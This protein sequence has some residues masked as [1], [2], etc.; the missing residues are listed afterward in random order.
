MVVSEALRITP[1]SYQKWNAV[2]SLMGYRESVFLLALI[3]ASE[4]RCDKEMLKQ[5]I[6]PA[7][8]DVSDVLLA[9]VAHKTRKVLRAHNIMVNIQSISGFGYFLDFLE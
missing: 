4:C 9:G 1:L 2:L 6:W 7:R 5:K 8:E 3:N